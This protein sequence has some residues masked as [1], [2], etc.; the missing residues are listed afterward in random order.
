MQTSSLGQVYSGKVEGINL[1]FFPPLSPQEVVAHWIAECRLSIEQARLLTLKTASK[2]DTLGNR[3]ARKEVSLLAAGTCA[4][5]Q[6]NWLKFK[7][8]ILLKVGLITEYNFTL[9]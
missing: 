6:E 7:L 2:I 1:F 8:K 4:F 3:R 5:S 9:Q